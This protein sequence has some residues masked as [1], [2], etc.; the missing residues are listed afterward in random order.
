MYIK[1][2]IYIIRKMVDENDR[3]VNKLA[4]IRTKLSNQSTYIVFIITGF[5]VA[6]VAASTTKN[7]W[8]IILGVVIILGGT[9]QYVLINNII[10]FERLIGSSLVSIGW[11]WLPIVSIPIS[12]LVLF[13][14]NVK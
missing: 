7:M 6:A 12:L 1:Y 2:Y 13:Y 9:V 11:Y 4:K 3:D 5:A 14:Q 8:L 10:Q